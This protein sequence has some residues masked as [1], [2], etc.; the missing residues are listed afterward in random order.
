MKHHLKYEERWLSVLFLKGAGLALRAQ[1]RLWEAEFLKAMTKSAYD[2]KRYNYSI[3]HLYGQE[4]S[5]IDK[6]PYT[7]QKISEDFGARCAFTGADRA[8]TD[9]AA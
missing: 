6:A 1:E 2:K 8:G 9:L 3:R 4:G 5:R 7:C